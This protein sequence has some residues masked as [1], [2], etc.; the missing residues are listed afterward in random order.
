VAGP[1]LW[2]LAT[3]V[4]D[5]PG[6]LRAL[7]GISGVATEV[8]WGLPSLVFFALGLAVTAFALWALA[9]LGELF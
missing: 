2:G 4:W 3:F 8:A 6:G 5:W 7:Y 1:V 9:K